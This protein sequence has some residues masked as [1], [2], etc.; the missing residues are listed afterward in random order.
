MT[1][2]P[3]LIRNFSVDD[4][5]GVNSIEALSFQAPWPSGFF[6]YLHGK[7]PGLFL[8][9]VEDGDVVGYVVGE[10]RE[11]MFSGVS[12]RYKMGHIL[13]IAVDIKRRRIGVGTQLLREMENRFRVRNANKITLEVRESNNAARS[14]YKKRG[15]EDIG[16]V[17]GYYVNE[18]A[19]IMCRSLQT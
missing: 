8:V 9:A 15:Y 7:A 13:N 11:I 5:E 1:A 17:K 18:D 14:F 2:L 3:I 6:R 4:I 10:L 12:H 16:R 19:V